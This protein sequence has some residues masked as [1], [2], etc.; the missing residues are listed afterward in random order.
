MKLL[1]LVDKYDSDPVNTRIFFLKY[2][3]KFF[4][5]TGTTH[6]SIFIKWDSIIPYLIFRLLLGNP[7]QP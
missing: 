5:S 4:G 2:A 1:T 7:Q 3:S 6:N